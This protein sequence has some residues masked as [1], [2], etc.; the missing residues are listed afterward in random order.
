M[1]RASAMERARAAWAGAA[2]DWI[3]RLAEACDAT[4]Q[5]RV[6]QD[7]EVSAAMIS[8]VLR[9]QYG[10]PTTTLERKVRG[11]LM[12][13][14]VACPVLGAIGIDAC[15]GHQSNA[16]NPK[17]LNAFNARLLRACRACPRFSQ[18]EGQ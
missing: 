7:L 6:A 4:S 18:K 5:N 15:F 2:P 9:N 13:V 10:A 8:N 14:T 3:L 16:R 11:R 12:D 1:S 17:G